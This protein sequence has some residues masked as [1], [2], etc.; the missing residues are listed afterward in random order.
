MADLVIDVVG[1]EG[2]HPQD[3]S[4]F[5]ENTEPLPARATEGSCQFQQIG[6]RSDETRIGRGNVGIF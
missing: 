6:S 5:A 2:L 3:V 1:L 4:L